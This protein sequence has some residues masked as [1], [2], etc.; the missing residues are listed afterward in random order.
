MIRLPLA[1]VLP[2]IVLLAIGS[3]SCFSGISAVAADKPVEPEFDPAHAEKM[4]EGLALFKQAVRPVLIKHCVDCHGGDEVQSGFDL[5]TRKGLLRG[6]SK[7]AAVA[8]GKALDSNLIRFISR[9]EKP[10]M[11]EGGDKLPDAEIDAIAKWIDLGAPYDKPLV[12]NP[13]DPDSWTTTVVADKAREFW[14][15]QPLQRVEP[16]AVKNTAWVRNSIDHF[17]LAKAEAKGLTPNSPASKRILLRRAYFD[18]IGLPPTP[19]QIE[20]FVKDE[21]P[22]AFEKVIDQLLESP[23]YGERWGRHWL[24]AARFAESHGFEQDYDRPFAFHFR[25]F[26]IKALNQDMPYDQFVRWQLAGDEFAPQEPLAQMATGFLGAG[27]FPTQITANEVEKSRYDALDDM[28]AT[29]G[30]ALLGLSI[31]CARCHD[32][33]FDPIPAADYYRFIATFATTV[34]SNV[35]INLKPAEYA[36]A[37]K[38]FDAE[39]APFV[40]AREKFEKEQLPPRFEQ[41]ELTSAKDAIGTAKWQILSIK[42]AKSKGNATLTPQG[43][44]SVLAG[45]ANPDFDVY[46]IDV[47]LPAGIYHGLRVEGLAD[48]SL[49]KGGPG[50]ADNGNFALT[51]LRVMLKPAGGNDQPLTLK[52]AQATFEQKPSLLVQHTIDGDKKSAW[53]VDPQF[54][55]DHAAVYELSEPLVVEKPA[56]LVFT[57]EFN[58]NN[59]HSLGRP[60]FAATSLPG[61]LS[62]EIGGMPAGIAAALATP[63]KERTAEQLQRLLTWYRTQDAQWTKLN[64][65][66][67]EHLK[68]QPQPTLTKV[69]VCSEGVTPIRHHTQ[70]ADFF[71]ETYFLKRGDNEQKMGAATPGFLQVL[72]TA[73]NREK[74]WQKPPPAGAKTSHRRSALAEWI[75]DT[76]FGGGQL[77]ARVM[78]NR[79]WHH[80]FGR[81]I[82]ATPNDFGV[83]GQRPTHP[84]LLD[85]LAKELIAR[86][87]KLKSMHKLI[88]T[89]AA[90]QQASTFDATDAKTDP[91]NQ[92]LWRFSPRRL[93]AEL[94]RDNLLAVS[95]KLD[96]TQFGPGTLDEAHL[97]RSIYFMIKRSKLVPMMQLFDQPEPL[98]SVGG[99]PSTTIAPQALMFINN[100]QVRSYAHAFAKQLLEAKGSPEATVRQAYL[101][102]IARE[103]D[104][105]ELNSA[106]AFLAEQGKSYQADGKAQPQELALADFCQVLFGLNEFVYV[107]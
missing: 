106:T 92:F 47:D 93:E 74:H 67:Q 53:A 78:A 68:K 35:D 91:E 34:R 13:R 86:E 40:A 17:V 37:K 16:P 60:R 6:G 4:Q 9:R 97:R 30:S 36:A 69:M 41:W 79:L 7:G 90:Y 28:A 10:Y 64:Q 99:R 71:A 62:V 15:F 87:W 33:K 85:W 1:N 54:G 61:P 76:E 51:D 20:A 75:T 104:A 65:A 77:L 48:P 73:P 98:V 82:V 49:K 50:R 12:D 94:V 43:D 58:N 39:H 31:G 66:E 26:V 24:D 45:G 81:G 102:A 105:D 70:G 95:G 59:K 2:A 55:K 63:A 88:M 11:P 80:H 25:D 29:T 44:G 27:V 89:S 3:L 107:E 56:T 101:Q 72:M 8:I 46:T 14:S 57:L 38:V 83:Q 84:E 96:R 21:S 100:P 5:A 42:Q 22:Q 32:H 52:N 103:P 19:A 18:L 23:H